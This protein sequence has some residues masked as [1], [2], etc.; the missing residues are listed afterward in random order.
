MSHMKDAMENEQ[1][2]AGGFGNLGLDP[3]LVA[4]LTELGYE[5]PTPIQRETIPL[6]L[7]GKDLIGQAATGTGKTAAFA[8]PMIQRIV[9]LAKEER[10]RP[11]ALILVPT[12]EL[13]MQVAEAMHKYGQK[14]RISTIPVYGGHSFGQ[15]QR[16]L[17]RG[18]D[19]VVAT[20]GRA[21][22]H[23]RRQTM[24]LSKLAV[25]ALD[26]ADEMLDMGFADD[27]EAILS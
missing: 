23:L 12:R 16:M 4:T 22:D 20:P 8:L 27:L 15:Q 14:L 18:V 2:T 26:E 5:E 1:E 3:K 6:L 19:V 9:G 7:T 17:E 21:L 10:G 11:S 24:D 13:C 25:L